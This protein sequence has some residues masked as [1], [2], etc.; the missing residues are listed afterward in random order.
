LSASPSISAN[1]SSEPERATARDD[2]PR[3]GQLGPVRG[4]D[5]VLDPFRQA[6]GRGRVDH[7]D[8]GGVARARRVEGRGAEGHDLLGIGRFHRLDRV[9]RV[10]RAL[11]R[12]GIDDARDA[13][14]ITITSS[15]A[16]TRGMMFLASVVA[17]AHD[18]V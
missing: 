1:C 9:A 16:A 13:S 8:R 18:M 2:D 4:R 10:D 12:V 7:L 15:S 17:G 11:E 3:R 6:G 14:E 5:L